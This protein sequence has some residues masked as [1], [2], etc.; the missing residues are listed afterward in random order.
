M[1]IREYT[2]KDSLLAAWV[3]DV[4]AVLSAGLTGLRWVDQIGPTISFAWN[5]DNAPQ[6]VR[7][8]LPAKPLS[9]V[10]LS[11]TTGDGIIVSGCP[12]FWIWEAEG[13]SIVEIDSLTLATDYTVTLGFVR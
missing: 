7:V 13:I 2:P 4:R 6:L 8:K 10:V 11:A 3:R 12:V 5:S 1:I 9:V